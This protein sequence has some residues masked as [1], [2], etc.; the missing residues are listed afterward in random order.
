MNPICPRSGAAAISAETISTPN[1]RFFITASL[2]FE[3]WLRR[4]KA[5]GKSLPL[6]I[7]ALL[8]RHLGEIESNFQIIV[9]AGSEELD[10]LFVR[11]DNVR[12]AGVLFGEFKNDG[13]CAPAI[14]SL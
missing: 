12:A 10:S 5:P 11:A 2:S 7:T 14:R 8:I 13:G 4:C 3:T 6:P 1:T 9:P